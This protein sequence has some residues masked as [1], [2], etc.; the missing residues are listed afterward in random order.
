MKIINKSLFILLL[1]LSYDTLASGDKGYWNYEA[2]PTPTIETTT[3]KR[4][5]MPM[6]KRPILPPP[7]PS[8]AV[9]LKMHPAQIKILVKQWRGRAIET[10]TPKDVQT[11]LTVQNVARKKAA[12]YAA[13]VGL[14]NQVNPN[15]SLKKEI[16]I[17]NTGRQALY[18]KRKIGV[19]SYLFS[20]K[21][22]YALLYFTDPSCKFCQVQDGILRQYQ[23]KYNWTIK[24]I[25]L[26]Q[27]PL[28]ASRFGVDITPSVI[29]VSKNQKD[30]I[31]IS[32]GITSLPE[33]K[34]NIYRGARL[35]TNNIN[36]AQFYTN[37]DE[38]GTGLDPLSTP[39]N[40]NKFKELYEKQ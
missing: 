31:P 18:K 35:L 13:V 19:D 29:L 39:K 11:Y 21:E 12:G 3:T 22:H 34:E 6:P 30:W 10:L 5:T 27:N 4:D 25:L 24:P 14:V 1:I 8:E 17:T 37:Q 40:N 15:L 33:L 38:L 36:P 9:L 28:L 7:L 23:N 32:Y 2:K 16:P 26:H 20:I